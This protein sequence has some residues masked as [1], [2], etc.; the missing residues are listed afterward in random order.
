MNKCRVCDNLNVENFEYNH[1]I[2]PGKEPHWRNVYCPICM[3]VSHY[4][5]DNNYQDYV[6]QYRNSS[7]R[8]V[9]PP[10]D[11][12]SEVTFYRS[13]QVAE[14]LSE[15]GINLEGKL[16]DFGG[17]NGFLSFGLKGKYN[18]DVEVADFDKYGLKIASCF[19]AKYVDLSSDKVDFS[20][21]NN[22][23][24]V[25]VLEHVESPKSIMMEIG[26]ALQKGSILYLEVPNIF[27]FPMKDPAH[28]TSFSKHSLC[29]LVERAGFE[30]VNSGFVS[31][32]KCADKYGYL[33][34]NPYENIFLIAIY[35]G[36]FKYDL[37]SSV[38]VFSLRLSLDFWY[39][40]IAITTISRRLILT[41]LM[42]FI[43]G[44]LVFFASLF[45]F[46]F[47]G[48]FFAKVKDFLKKYKGFLSQS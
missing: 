48:I 26:G 18:V 43:K 3:A 2:F 13:F 15:S 21:Y 25:H 17:Y 1:P 45:S 12:W 11:P 46:G 32:P 27:G 40:L 47:L 28:L 42:L 5:H 22:I 31:S 8:S 14:L 23:I 34:R 6:D 7:N 16:L 33:Y 44:I 38:S 35:S 37:K 39:N 36:N 9:K 19:G 20:I 4:R 24:M 30:I 41:G 29:R 10:I